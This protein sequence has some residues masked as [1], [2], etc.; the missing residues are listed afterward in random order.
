MENVRLDCR[1]KKFEVQVGIL[2]RTCATDP[3]VGV[4]A[5]EVA[6]P[7]VVSRICISANVSVDFPRRSTCLGKVQVGHSIV[8]GIAEMNLFNFGA[9]RVLS[10]EEINCKSEIRRDASGCIRADHCR[11]D[12]GVR[13]E[14][15]DEADVHGC[16]DR[17][18]TTNCGF[19]ES[20]LPKYL[21][22]RFPGNA[23]NMCIQHNVHSFF[24][25]LLSVD[26]S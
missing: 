18:V 23:P 26:E 3:R 9:R 24:T 2:K 6:I 4:D 14:E 16:V 19:S 15:K 12:D 1:E 11:C 8:D 10:I 21:S 25:P 22:E 13:E 7:A 5:N 17:D 20:R